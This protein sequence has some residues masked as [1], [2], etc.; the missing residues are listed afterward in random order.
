MVGERDMVAYAQ[1]LCRNA[2]Y[3]PQDM[4]DDALHSIP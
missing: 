4:I 1:E 2:D 3:D